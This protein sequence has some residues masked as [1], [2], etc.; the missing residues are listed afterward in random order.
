[1]RLNGPCGKFKLTNTADDHVDL[2]LG[3]IPDAGFSQEEIETLTIAQLTLSLK[4]RRI[5]QTDNKK[6]LLRD[7]SAVY[8]CSLFSTT[9][10][11]RSLDTCFFTKFAFSGSRTCKQ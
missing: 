6:E 10:L 1:M 9:S 5:N 4:C 2:T 8:L 11:H 3:D 7:R